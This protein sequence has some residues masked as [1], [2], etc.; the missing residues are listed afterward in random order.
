LAPDRDDGSAASPASDGFVDASQLQSDFYLECTMHKQ[1]LPHANAVR[2]VASAM[3]LHPDDVS[4]AGVKDLQGDTI[5][6]IRLRGG[7]P[8]AAVRA[9]GFFARRL[10]GTGKSLRLSNFA[11]QRTPLIP[12]ML[13]GN[14]FRIILRDVPNWVTDGHWDRAVHLLQTHGS[15]NF[16]GCQRFSWFGGVE[17]DPGFALLN[18]DLISYVHRELGYTTEC[19]TRTMREL[20]QRPRLY[21]LPFQESF[22]RKLVRTL[23]DRQVL[24]AVLDADFYRLRPAYLGERTR[25]DQETR[26]RDRKV[27]E[28]IRASLR[29]LPGTSRRLTCQVFLSYLWNQALSERLALYG[30]RPLPGDFAIPTSLRDTADVKPPEFFAK[31]GRVLTEED[32][33]SGSA[34]SFDVM[35]PSFSFSGRTLPDNAT[36]CIFMSLCAR[37]GLDWHLTDPSRLGISDFTEGPRPMLARPTDV[38]WERVDP[39][40]A[41]RPG[42]VSASGATPA[43]PETIVASMSHDAAASIPTTDGGGGIVALSF[44]LPRGAYA[45]VAVREVLRCVACPGAEGVSRRPLQAVHWHTLGARDPGYTLKIE[46]AYP[47]F[48][49]D[50]GIIEHRDPETAPEVDV[51]KLD[52][53]SRYT[54]DPAAV[55]QRWAKKVFMRNGERQHRHIEKARRLLMEPGIGKHMDPNEVLR[56]AGHTVPMRANAPRARLR[57]AVL[58]RR[59]RGVKG[60]QRAQLLDTL[61]I[62]TRKQDGVRITKDF[63]DTR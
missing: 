6:R 52:S 43:S 28:C 35:L 9:N 58:S 36:R 40:D 33:A 19:G 55:V 51:Y 7:S 32:I 17:H 37:Y 14:H 56:Y 16:Y 1:F 41:T 5:Q 42:F 26:Q 54:H 46:D 2:M 10:A 60:S 53:E 24:P 13:Q 8:L 18:N 30:S 21:P 38:R 57:R 3:R 20:L 63:W 50:V 59:L 49:Q 39:A 11:Y 22:R 29:S 12:G 15:P 47:T 27:L 4:I 31:H 62:R 61:T 44:S 34:T 23:R 48:S 45:N 25:D